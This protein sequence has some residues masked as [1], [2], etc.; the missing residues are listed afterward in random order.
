MWI[1]IYSE[2]PSKQQSVP[3]GC[4]NYINSSV[5]FALGFLSCLGAS[6]Q[7]NKKHRLL[8]VKDDIFVV[9]TSKMQI[10]IIISR[11][12]CDSR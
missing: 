4:G 1:Y 5:L 6:A 3:L 2:F 7:H 10:I 11:I 9:T 8:F 12:A